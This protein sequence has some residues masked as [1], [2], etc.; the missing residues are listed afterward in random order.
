MPESQTVALF[1][2]QLEFLRTRFRIVPLKEAVANLGDASGT[3]DRRP[4]AA[5]TFDD[6]FLDNYEHAFP[7]LK[8][9]GVPATIFVVTDFVDQGRVPWPTR[10]YEVMLQAR[11][12]AHPAYPGIDLRSRVA[13][14]AAAYTFK[15]L[16]APLEP[17]ARFAAIDKLADDLEAPPSQY[18]PLTWDQVRIMASAGIAFGSHT[19][20]HSILPEMSDEVVE[21]ELGVSRTRL[22]AEL[23]E[24]CSTVAYPNGGFDSR[25]LRMTQRCG[26]RVGVTQQ[27]GSNSQRSDVLALCRVHIPPHCTQG[28]VAML[29]LRAAWQEP[30]DRA[31]RHFA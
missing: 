11:R 4:I 3:K 27:A 8:Q 2:D 26:Y 9:L 10:L 1:R 17:H 29:L 31:T 18:R 30:W 13:R 12:I 23:G 19:V 16:L 24:E 22:E 6:G 5:I 21:M 25:I 28:V 7:C 15:S 20:F 14:C